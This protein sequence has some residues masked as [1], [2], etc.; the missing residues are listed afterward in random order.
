M[1][2]TR[3][4]IYRSM[5]G[6]TSGRG[7]WPIVTVPSIGSRIAGILRLPF[8]TVFMIE[9]KKSSSASPPP[10]THTTIEGYAAPHPDRK[11]GA[12]LASGTPAKPVPGT[13]SPV[14]SKLE[15][16]YRRQDGELGRWSLGG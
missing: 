2:R 12:K 16:W 8:S 3:D 10:I 7:A 1:R 11:V 14:R 13:I 6:T 5:I 4:A 15:T 9:S